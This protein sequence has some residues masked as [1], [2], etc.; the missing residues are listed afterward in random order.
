MSNISQRSLSGGELSPSLYARTD[1]TKYT[2]GLR[3]CRNFIL[4]RHGGA[5]NR[6]GTVF[7]SE[8]K[9]STSTA[10]LAKFVYN[11]AQTYVLEFTDRALRFYQLGGQVVTSGVSAWAT[12]TVYTVNGLVTQSGVTYY[13]IVAHTSGATTQPGIGASWATYWYAL[14]GAV[15]EIPTPYAQADLPTLQWVQSA[16]VVTIVHPS[17]AP[18]ELRRT[19]NTAWSLTPIVFN[20]AIG[21][22]SNVIA[23]GGGAGVVTYWAV[24]AIDTATGEE[25]LPV[26]YSLAARVP[27]AGTPTTL[28]WDA[29]GSALSYVVYRSPDGST[30]GMLG[31]ASGTPQAKTTTTWTTSTSTVSGVSTGAYALATTQCR[32]VPVAVLADKSYDNTYTISANLTLNGSGSAT[33]S[34]YGRVHVYY[35][36]GGETRVFAG[37]LGDPVAVI[38]P[39]SSDTAITGTITVPDNGYTTLT[40]DLVPAVKSNSTAS[41]SAVAATTTAPTNSIAWSVI[42]TGYLDTGVTPNYLS[43]PPTKATLFVAPDTY[44]SAVTYY[45][46]RRM[47]ANTNTL[48]ERVW[49]SRTG[50]FTSFTTSTPI[51]SDDMVS[52][53]L[54]SRQVNNIRHMVGVG[55]LLLFTA[56]GEW[57]VGESEADIL[58]PTNINARQMVYHG[59]NFLPPLVVGN[60]VLYVQARGNIVRDIFS[61][62][63]QGYKTNDLTLFANH[64]VDGYTL[65]DWDFAQTPHSTLWVVRS[66]GVLLSL[67]YIREQ[68]VWGWARHDTD[69]IVENVCVVPEGLED[70]IYLVVKR[71]IGGVAKRYVERMAS[72]VITAATDITSLHFVDCGLTYDGR[73]TST[74]TVTLSGGVAWDTTETITVTRSVGGFVSTNVG[75]RIDI[76]LASGIILRVTLEGYTSTTVMTGRAQALVPVA[77]RGVA[78]AAWARAVRIVTGLSHLEGKALAVFADGHVAASPNNP[79]YPVVTVTGGSLTLDQPYRVIRAGLPY[80]SD[81]ETLDVDTPSGPSMKEKFQRISRVGL[82]VESSRGIWAGM[83]V[84]ADTSLTNMLEYKARDGEA[85]ATPTA[86]KTDYIEVGIESNWVGNGRVGIRQVDPLP[87]TILSVAPQGNLSQSA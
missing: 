35:S 63:V 33:S 66:D 4:L 34:T 78:T 18:R 79:A 74:E 36:R 85:Y 11:D 69:G 54:A 25:G 45:Q 22:V 53:S 68:D 44:P 83:A 32:A 47:F 77:L 52:F 49:G 64:L 46:Q 28:N 21:G 58:T 10:R 7:L 24:T 3:T 9:T 87:L 19:G 73:N 86:L 62:V 80:I 72:R 81:M 51:Q 16:D 27:S 84:P 17:Y 14:T 15:Y 20:P 1:L 31:A 71:T 76:T 26:F 42:R 43:T 30:Y 61:D 60:V 5:A 13:C 67:T 82:T 48:P 38:G 23:T 2:T 56:S 50:V 6:P 12:T 65:V 40:I 37:I 8:I 29:L 59:A 55:R 41:V 57:S 39:V 70:A 75:D